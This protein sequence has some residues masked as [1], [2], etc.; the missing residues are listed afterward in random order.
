MASGSSRFRFLTRNLGI[1]LTAITVLVTGLASLEF[2]RFL[3][4]ARI[5]LFALTTAAWAAHCVVNTL[6]NP[7]RSGKLIVSAEGPGQEIVQKATFFSLQQLD[8]F[9]ADSA[10]AE[11]FLRGE[12]AYVAYRYSQAASHYKES[13]E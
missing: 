6:A 1:A 3:E 7:L 8:G 4:P 11:S 13:L 10:A 2:L 5:P 12:Q 9:E